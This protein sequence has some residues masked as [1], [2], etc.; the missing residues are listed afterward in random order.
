MGHLAALPSPSLAQAC[1]RAGAGKRGSRL[2]GGVGH[3]HGRACGCRVEGRAGG[4]PRQFDFPQTFSVSAWLAAADGAGARCSL[5]PSLVSNPPGASGPPSGSRSLP[6]ACCGAGAPRPRGCAGGARGRARGRSLAPAGSVRAGGQ[7][8]FP[9]RPYPGGNQSS[10]LFS[11]SLR[12]LP[13]VLRYLS[14]PG[15]RVAPRWLG[16]GL[17]VAKIS[18]LKTTMES[19]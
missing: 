14:L 2:P 12:S 13:F 3:G 1:G 17:A 18:H 8:T 9:P 7:A 6:W 10:L 19:F 5:P 4:R 15:I 11:M 16:G